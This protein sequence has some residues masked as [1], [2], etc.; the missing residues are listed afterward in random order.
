MSE[1]LGMEKISGYHTVLCYKTQGPTN[2][3]PP[4]V[5]IDV[6]AGEKR[7]DGKGGMRLHLVVKR[8]YDCL[9]KHFGKKERGDRYLIFRK[10]KNWKTENKLIGRPIL[11]KKFIA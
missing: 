3:N 8:G 10:G 4:L 5:D 6:V 2:Y 11:E 9:R 7:P 1:V